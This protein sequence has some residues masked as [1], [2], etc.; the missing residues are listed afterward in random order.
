V[1][2]ELVSGVATGETVRVIA[3][4]VRLRLGGEL[5]RSLTI[6]RTEVLRAYRA[7]ALDSYRASG[8]VTGY[9]WLATKDI[10]TCLVCLALDGQV[11]PLTRPVPAHINCRCSVTPVLD[12][13]EPPTESAAE[14]FAKLSEGAQRDMLK[15]GYEAYRAGKIALLDFVGFKTSAAWGTTPYQRPL[16]EI[17][18]STGE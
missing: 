15:G 11:F 1:S 4:R 8:V 3:S 13:Q 14:W 18:V 9:R 2:D 6:S 10:R 7:A 5:T 16:K 17:L 12:G